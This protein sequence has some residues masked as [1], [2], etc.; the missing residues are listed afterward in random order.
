MGYVSYDEL[1][2]NLARYLDSAAAS[3]LV[4]TRAGGNVVMMSEAEFNGWKETAYILSSPRNAAQL[5]E[6]IR[7]LG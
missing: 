7:Q 3:P 5:L 4:V 6:S 1:S 2:D